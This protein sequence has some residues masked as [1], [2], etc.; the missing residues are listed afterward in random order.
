MKEQFVTYNIAL[1]LKELGFDEE[2]LAYYIDPENPF[3]EDNHGNKT[4]FM[5]I[6]FIPH[7]E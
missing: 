7:S 1:K 2:C 3:Y 4:N 5:C 6:H